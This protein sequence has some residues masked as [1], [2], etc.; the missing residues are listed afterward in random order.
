MKAYT[1]VWNDPDRYTKNIIPIGTNHPICAYFRMIGKKMEATGLI[2][3]L[4]SK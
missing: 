3:V 1:L 4:I 2:Y